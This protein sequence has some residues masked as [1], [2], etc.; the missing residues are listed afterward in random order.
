MRNNARNNKRNQEEY[1][2]NKHQ[3]TKKL[4]EGCLTGYEHGHPRPII[5]PVRSDCIHME[6]GVHKLRKYKRQG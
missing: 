2:G 3:L 4:T 6:G 1:D 5:V